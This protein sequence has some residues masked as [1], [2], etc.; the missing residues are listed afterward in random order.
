MLDE[1]ALTALCSVT[2]RRRERTCKR[3]TN[4]KQNKCKKRD[5][6]IFK[7]VFQPKIA[8]F[9]CCFFVIYHCKLCCL[10][11][12]FCLLFINWQNTVKSFIYFPLTMC[13]LKN[14]VWVFLIEQRVLCCLSWWKCISTIIWMH[15]EGRQVRTSASEGV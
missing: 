2:L 12:Y 6:N 3:E 9:L 15:L 8:L 11:I 10:F 1:T 4:R 14:F 5:D 7:S 13:E